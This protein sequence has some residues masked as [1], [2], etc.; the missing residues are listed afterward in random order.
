[1]AS[2]GLSEGIGQVDDASGDRKKWEE[3]LYKFRWPAVFVLVGLLLA[4]LGLIF[5]R[6]SVS[7]REDGVKVLD[8]ATQ[9]DSGQNLV[10]E[11]AGSVVSPG[12]YNLPADSRVDDALTAAG[13]LAADAD[14]DWLTKSVN[15]AAKVTDGQKI[16][17]KSV[18]D[19]TVSGVSIDSG[20]SV[21]G[22]SGPININTASQNL[23][24]S[25]SGIGPV[26]AQKIIEYR[27][28]S[29][30]EELLSKKVLGQ[31]VYNKNK[32]LLTVY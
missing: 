14:T 15:R 26:T 17:V 8:A 6:G 1:M 9:S 2:D 13:G 28:Y 18:D 20:G 23:L 5:A 21:S 22:T 29:S 31:S 25:L 19:T 27:P 30:V 10:V 32:D 24:E 3:L 4:A 11:V 7:G 12:V 16:Y